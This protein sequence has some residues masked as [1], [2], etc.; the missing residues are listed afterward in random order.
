MAVAYIS[1]P[2]CASY[3]LTID[4]SFCVSHTAVPFG[5]VARGPMSS[6]WSCDF[7]LPEGADFCPQCGARQETAAGGSAEGG[8]S[9]DAPDDV[10]TGTRMGMPIPVIPKQPVS[11]DDLAATMVMDSP[12]FPPTET[13]TFDGVPDEPSAPESSAKT[14]V[15]DGPSIVTPIPAFDA[16]ETRTESTSL[17][18]PVESPD[19]NAS[20]LEI[21]EQGVGSSELR[22]GS[23]LLLAGLFMLLS[24]TAGLVWSFTG[25]GKNKPEERLEKTASMEP[26][27]L[28]L[29]QPIVGC[30][31]GQTEWVLEGQ[32]VPGAVMTVAAEKVSVRSDGYFRWVKPLSEIGSK[33]LTVAVRGP[34]MAPVERVLQIEQPSE[35][36]VKRLR[37]AARERVR[38]GHTGGVADFNEVMASLTTHRGQRLYFEGWLVAMHRIDQ[39]SNRLLLKTCSGASGCP[40]WI[41]TRRP[42]TVD[43]GS[44][45]AGFGELVGTEKYLN[46]KGEWR[47]ALLL[48]QG[49][50]SP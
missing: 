46:I 3:A 49:Q 23:K 34:D 26:T 9:A 32:T 11:D 17:V 41:E 47:E 31:A 25:E 33:D 13:S 18:N 45:V 50:V 12:I 44:P 1:S 20:S 38:K 7:E 4:C 40:V 42:I 28:A 21:S 16:P 6:C 24:G 43:V 36:E 22:S 8:G 29:R 39:T 35:G 5:G 27:P 2:K 10:V 15:I 48:A 14:V 30:C 19:S 37:D